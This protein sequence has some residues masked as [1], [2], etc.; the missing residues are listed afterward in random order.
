MSI[1]NQS[2]NVVAEEK[3]ELYVEDVNRCSLWPNNEEDSEEQAPLPL[4]E[5]CVVLQRL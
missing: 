1:S 3:R 5:R 2:T 4:V